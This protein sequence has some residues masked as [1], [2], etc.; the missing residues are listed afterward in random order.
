MGYRSFRIICVVRI[1]LLAASILA[2][3]YLLSF[4]SLLAT[5]LIVAA[6]IV[7]QIVSLIHYVEKTNRD[8]A[9]FL[10]SI[11]YSD[12]SQTFSAGQ[13]GSAFRE[14]H[15]AFADVMAEFQRARAERETQYRY[16]QT[17]VQHIGLAILSFDQT[18]TVDLMNNAAKRLLR[19]NHLRNIKSLNLFNILQTSQNIIPHVSN[20]RSSAI[21]R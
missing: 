11:K 14:L 17:L 8:L 13:K 5:S 3:V 1:L 21:A 20:H 12:F 6:A 10:A 2:L 4:T 9:R 18:G 19:V 7:A 16:L 15:A